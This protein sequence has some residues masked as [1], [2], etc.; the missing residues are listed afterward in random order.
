MDR[1]LAGWLLPEFRKG[2]DGALRVLRGQV[3]LS[4]LLGAAVGLT[5]Y[6]VGLDPLAA[7]IKYD[8][9]TAKAALSGD[10]YA[11]LADLAQQFGVEIAEFLP[12]DVESGPH[13]RTPGALL[14]SVP[15]VVMP[16]DWLFAFAT[17]VSVACIAYLVGPTL[18]GLEPW[19]KRAAIAFSIVTIPTLGTIRFGAQSAMVAVLVLVAWTFAARNNSRTGG[20]L[21]GIAVT[22]KV[23]PVLLLVPL[24]LRRRLATLASVLLSLAVLNLV[25]LALPGVSL[26]GAVEAFGEASR[27]WVDMPGNA[28]AMTLLVKAGMDARAGLGAIALLTTLVLFF[29]T[30]RFRERS[31]LDPLPWLVI[32]LLVIPI[33]WSHYDVIL[34]PVAVTL[35]VSRH[36][37][38]LGYALPAV[39]LVISVALFFNDLATGP[40]F[41]AARVLLLLAWARTL[42]QAT[43]DPQGFAWRTIKP[44]A[45]TP[46]TSSAEPA[47]FC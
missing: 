17:A 42:L 16:F 30:T 40:W 12:A 1:V 33:S 38:V 29:L 4:I 14:L 37:A 11:P 8:W 26:A 31:S 23:F 6:V 13:P 15:L 19:W 43:N 32:G 45:S 41:L 34:L 7:D 28:S 18:R 24:L 5:I 46:G 44:S 22:L 21:I 9:L 25:G 35:L 36:R 27:I 10:A 2:I 3:L 20:V 47:S 39:W